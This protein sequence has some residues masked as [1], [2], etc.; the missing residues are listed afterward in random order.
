[1]KDR[2]TA[3]ERLAARYWD[4]LD[5]YPR[6]YRE[7]RG[8]E[9]VGTLL[10][11]AEPGQTRPSRREA[12]A[13]VFEGLRMRAGTGDHRPVGVTVAEGLRLGLLVLLVTMTIEGVTTLGTARGYDD[14]RP[15]TAG[16]SVL[17]GLAVLAGVVPV[18]LLARGRTRLALPFVA[19][20]GAVQTIG[21]PWLHHVGWPAMAHRPLPEE[22][23]LLVPLYLYPGPATAAVLGALALAFSRLRPLRGRTVAGAVLLPALV[24]LPDWLEAVGLLPSTFEFYALPTLLLILLGY[25]GVMGYAAVDARPAIALAFLVSAVAAATVVAW[26][27]FGPGVSEAVYVLVITVP[28]ASAGWLGARRRARIPAPDVTVR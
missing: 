4:L 25:L 12:R 3:E 10:D 15:V 16:W 1:M 11:C 7:D 24:W 28:V 27:K 8:A 26:L 6:R 9:L 22:W 13:L 23:P 5:Y 20:A 21:Y 19:V 2:R 14:V 18:A 17:V